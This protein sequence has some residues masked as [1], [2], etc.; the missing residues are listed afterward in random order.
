MYV[1]FPQCPNLQRIRAFINTDIA[2][3]RLP[4]IYNLNTGWSK[5]LQQIQSC[6]IKKAKLDFSSV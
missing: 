2:W 3:D 4:F 5:Y 6:T 1:P